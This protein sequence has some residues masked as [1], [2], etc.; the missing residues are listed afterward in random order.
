MSTMGEKG[1]DDLRGR[2]GSP[3]CDRYHV[4][5]HCTLFKNKIYQDLQGKLGWDS[6]TYLD[7]K[8][9]LVHD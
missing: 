7:M 3:G 2:C 5:K 4:P 1:I 9:D 6:H 8:I